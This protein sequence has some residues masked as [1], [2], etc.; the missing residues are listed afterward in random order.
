MGSRF[1][2]AA[3]DLPIAPRASL[4]V[5][6][7]EAALMGRLFTALKARDAREL[8]A[9]ITSASFGTV[10]RMFDRINTRNAGTHFVSAESHRRAK[11]ELKARRV[12]EMRAQGKSYRVISDELKIGCQTIRHI[13]VNNR[14]AEAAE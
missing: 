2:H 7:T 14:Q 10:R 1:R 12:L 13:I 4:S 9:C 8:Y 5:S 3:F 11:Y 6:A